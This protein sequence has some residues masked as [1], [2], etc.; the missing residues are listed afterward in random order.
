MRELVFIG[1]VGC[2]TSSGFDDEPREDA[3]SVAIDDASRG[4]TAD[5]VLAL[6]STA[7][8]TGIVWDQ[9]SAGGSKAD[10]TL[11]IAGVADAVQIVSRSACHESP[12]W[13][14][15]MLRVPM[16][17]TVTM[18]AGQV[19]AD[20]L[21]TVDAAYVDSL[22]HVRLWTQWE[23]PATLTGQDQADL[24]DHIE[25]GPFPDAVLDGVYVTGFGVWTEGLIDIETQSH[26]DDAVSGETVWRGHWVF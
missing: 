24:T 1:M 23:L 6:V 14:G 21:V 2:S 11:S 19:V 4:F 16:E 7:L 18:A 17:A 25:S 10:L 3:T 22:D 15:P 9:I 5:D 26:T 12:P 13:V 8:P 20:G